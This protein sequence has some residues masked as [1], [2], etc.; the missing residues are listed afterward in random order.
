MKQQ[1]LIIDDDLPMRCLLHG[2]LSKKYVVTSMGSGIEACTWLS[3]GNV[4]DLIISDLCMPGMDG[5]E[6]LQTL[7]ESGLYKNIPVII[8]S[9]MQEEWTR[10][11][12]L[13]EGAIDYL[14]KPFELENL[15]AAVDRPLVSKMFL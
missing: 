5:M 4:P 3:E 1:I 14:N 10:K 12:C 2:I 8:L 6:F 7:Q 13:A 11:R 9:T 15:M